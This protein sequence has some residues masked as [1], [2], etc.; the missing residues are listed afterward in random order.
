MRRT[1]LSGSAMLALLAMTGCGGG[2]STGTA[3][4]ASPGATASSSAASAQLNDAEVMFAQMMIPHHEQ[5]V[6]MADL[7]ATR[8]K[9]PDLKKL[10]A[11]IKAAQAPEITTMAG[12]LTAMGKP[13]EAPGGHQIHGTD[14]MPGMVSDKDLAALKAASG[15]DFDRMFARLM[16]AHHNGAIQMARTVQS[17]GTNAEAKNLAAAIERTQADEV[18]T[19]QKFL[20]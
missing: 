19:L 3:D 7:A 16:I 2:E 13:T 4:N 17:D 11:Q 18:Q 14:A 15:D 20:G 5:A 10:A 6:E 9:D 1:L 8:V 12:W